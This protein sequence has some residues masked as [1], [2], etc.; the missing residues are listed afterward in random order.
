MSK[1]MTK[2]EALEHWANLEP[3]QNPLKHMT[4]I[5]A[6]AKG[7]K[8]GACGIRADGNQAFVDAVLSCVKPL[9]EGESGSTRL[10]LSYQEVKPTTINGKTKHYENKDQD[11]VCV[12]I[13]LHK[14]G[15]EKAQI[16]NNPLY[17]EM[18]DE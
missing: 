1:T 14:R 11:S 17:Q 7:S 12:Y 16:L 10:Q 18:F 3:N 8:F 15:R 9:L 6:T 2:K 5:D 4:A 13:R